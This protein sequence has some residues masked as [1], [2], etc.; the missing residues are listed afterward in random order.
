[1]V[2]QSPHSSSGAVESTQG[3][4]DTR[5]TAFSPEDVRPPKGIKFGLASASFEATPQDPFVSS[6]SRNKIDQKLSATASAF[7]PFSSKAS[8][9]G[10][11]YSTPVVA[12]GS[13]IGRGTEKTSASQLVPLDDAQ[14]SEASN[15]GT[16]TSDTGASRCIRMK[17]I[18]N[19][20]VLPLAV[21]S[22]E[23]RLR[24]L[25]F[26]SINFLHQN[27]VTDLGSNA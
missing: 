8:K 24:S 5:L 1:M 19:D 3:T 7:Q 4:P 12:Y 27:N 11:S 6:G 16:F 21:L 13:L 10:P 9:D 22:L 17:S 18:Y 20:H 14:S 15:Y 26:F 23:V 2:N 25:L